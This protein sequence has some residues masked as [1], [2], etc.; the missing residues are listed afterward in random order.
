MKSKP[1]ENYLSLQFKDSTTYPPSPLSL[2]INFH[3]HPLMTVANRIHAD[4]MKEKVPPT[5]T[6]YN[7]VGKLMKTSTYRCKCFYTIFWALAWKFTYEL[8]SL[9]AKSSDPLPSH[10]LY[11]VKIENFHPFLTPYPGVLTLYLTFLR[12]HKN[13]SIT[14][15]VRFFS[16]P[17]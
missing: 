16:D 17:K 4:I 11:I 9:Q 8:Q 13:P 12:C 2:Q 10:Y 7:G 1:V 6:T 14:G 5:L 15:V 3:P